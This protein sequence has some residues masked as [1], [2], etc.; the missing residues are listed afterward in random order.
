MSYGSA[1]GEPRADV[2]RGSARP[3]TVSGMSGHF[4]EM[5]PAR[6]RPAGR[7]V[8]RPAGLV[9]SASNVPGRRWVLSS[10]VSDPAVEGEQ[11]AAAA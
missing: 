7:P 4:R 2:A 11:V 5:L 6:G 8:T 9:T 10:P 1:S 3:H